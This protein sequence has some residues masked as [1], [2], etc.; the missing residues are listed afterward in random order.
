M[1]SSRE[2]YPKIVLAK[3]SELPGLVAVRQV[4]PKPPTG[5]QRALSAIHK[6]C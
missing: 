4:F 3:F 6:P 2:K 5:V 1:L